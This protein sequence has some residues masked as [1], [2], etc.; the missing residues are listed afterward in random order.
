MQSR[1]FLV[2]NKDGPICQ[3]YGLC[4]FIQFIK[5]IFYHNENSAFLKK[6][7][8]ITNKIKKQKIFLSCLNVDSRIL[9]FWHKLHL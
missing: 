1:T 8:Q 9:Q 7:Y 3:L 6:I 4:S 2:K 5:K